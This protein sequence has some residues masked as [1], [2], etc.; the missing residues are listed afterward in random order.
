MAI[1]TRVLIEL[2]LFQRVGTSHCFVRSGEDGQFGSTYLDALK[3]A[4]ENSGVESSGSFRIGG[5]GFGVA[6]RILASG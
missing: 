4:A 6:N 3:S 2:N 5:G 1:E